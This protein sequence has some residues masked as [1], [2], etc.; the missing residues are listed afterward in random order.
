MKSKLMVLLSVVLA[1]LL[2]SCAAPGGE[3]YNHTT[4]QD[5]LENGIWESAPDKRPGGLWR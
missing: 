2:S 3:S 5:R 4:Y 1:V